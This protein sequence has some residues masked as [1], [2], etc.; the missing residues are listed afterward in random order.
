MAEILIKAQEP[1]NN[2]DPQAPS[3]RSRLGYN[4]DTKEATWHLQR[5]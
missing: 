5:Q 1:Y 3:E 2:D 4:N